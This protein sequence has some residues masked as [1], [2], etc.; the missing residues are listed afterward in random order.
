MKIASFIKL[1][2]FI[3]LFSISTP[4][5]IKTLSNIYFLEQYKKKEIVGGNTATM[6]DIHK[7]GGN[8]IRI[9]YEIMN[10]QSNI[11]TLYYRFDN[12]TIPYTNFYTNYSVKL[13]RFNINRDRD[14]Y[15][16]YSIYEFIVPKDKNKYYNYLTVINPD[17]H[18]M[19]IYSYGFYQSESSNKYDYLFYIIGAAP[20][21]II[22]IIFICCCICKRSK[23]K[24]NPITSV[25]LCTNGENPQ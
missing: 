25:P 8:R 19:N 3:K 16:Y 22:G 1:I 7:F 10:N 2:F 12:K 4:I 13:N 5:E 9:Q 23:R 18:N 20:L 17:Y 21:I 24:N 6:I 14:Y 15:D 11:D